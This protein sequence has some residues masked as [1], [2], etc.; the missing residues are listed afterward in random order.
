MSVRLIASDL[1]GTLFGP[2]HRPGPRTVAAIN[3]AADAGIIVAAVTGRSHFGGAPLAVSTGARLDWFIGSN[4]GHRL[5]YATRE[6]EERLVFGD[7]DVRDL[8]AGVEASLGVVGFGWEVHD[9]FVWS[10]SFIDLH[11]S[12]IGNY[13]AGNGSSAR[14]ARQIGDPLDSVGKIFVAHPDV[15]TTGLVEMVSGLVPPGVNV[16]T[17][18]ASFVEL[19]PSGAD[20]GSALARLC[21]R[22]GI[23][24]AE[25]VAFGDNQNDLTMLAWAGRGI[26]MANAIDLVKDQADEV[27]AS[28]S[29]HGVAAVVESILADR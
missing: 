11:P 25:V 23:A 10:Q 26:A 17:S 12:F 4:G 14:V 21:D 24:A 27:T 8:C 16:T 2:D 19:T 13:P 18:G 9:G 28:N 3:A 6:I 7:D 20:K 22:I 15:V 5:N 29:D 1:D